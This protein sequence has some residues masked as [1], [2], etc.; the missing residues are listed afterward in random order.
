MPTCFLENNL[1]RLLGKVD[2]LSLNLILDMDRAPSEREERTDIL[3]SERRRDGIRVKRGEG[4]GTDDICSAATNGFTGGEPYEPHE[5][6]PGV[7]SA[8]GEGQCV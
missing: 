5:E 7:D 4:S 1:A 6:V 3:E 8:A 2:D